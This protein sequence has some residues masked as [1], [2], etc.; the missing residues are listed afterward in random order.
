M[1]SLLARKPQKAAWAHAPAGRIT[2]AT[3]GI[4]LLGGVLNRPATAQVAAGQPAVQRGVSQAEVVAMH[5]A[6]K[7]AV[8]PAE[9]SL[10]RDVFAGS[11][12]INSAQ[13][14]VGVRL[15]RGPGAICFRRPRP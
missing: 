15:V 4:L 10:E 14:Q 1:L 9:T 2:I 5:A 6:V 3:F 12:I 7:R 13:G 8:P 11:S